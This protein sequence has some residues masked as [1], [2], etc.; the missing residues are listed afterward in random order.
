MAVPAVRA[1]LEMY[2]GKLAG[3]SE[4]EILEGV[5]NT[6]RDTLITRIENKSSVLA[7]GQLQREAQ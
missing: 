4:E 1:A 6:V 3:A 2:I 5:L 7:K